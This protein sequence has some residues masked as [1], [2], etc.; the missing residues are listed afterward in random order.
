MDNFLIRVEN[1]CKSYNGVDIL[2]DVS[3]CISNNQKIGLVGKNGVGKSTL[4]KIISGNE[5]EY[6]GK[7]ILGNDI[8]TIGYLKQEFNIKDMNKTVSEY[9][10]EAV[11]IKKLKE[12]L[13]ILGKSDLT[14]Q[15]N[16]DAFN[17]ANEE[18]L[19][20]DGYNF[21]YKK[22]STFAGL[23]LDKSF[24]NKKISM[25]SGG[26]KSKVLLSVVLLSNAD[27]LLLDEPTNNLDIKSIEWLDKYLKA[28]NN[29]CIIISHDRVLLD[30][31][32]TKIIEIDYDTRNS[33]EYTGNYSEYLKFK[34][35][36]KAKQLELYENQQELI[37]NMNK[38]IKQKK[39]WATYGRYQ[40]VSDN[41]KY[42]R[43][44]ERNRSSSV[45]S[46]AKRIEKKI[47]Q[48]NKIE[49]P[50]IH[51]P[52]KIKLNR[53]CQENCVSFFRKVKI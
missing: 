20:I 23:S 10:D 27:L 42:T 31:L 44:Y 39:A 8:H 18:L 16:Y 2:N 46:S 37:S 41:D 48:M 32:V 36:Q 1:I 43:G 25:L 34:S 9:I 19:A 51:E 30:N 15:E 3:F 21:D 53:I 13:E 29:M 14:I 7:I 22:E 17:S 49:R 5:H 24:L 26:Q 52:L 11:G 38:S 40:G 47:H 45:A 6:S 12:R 33:V 4:M 28:I 35:K 50:I